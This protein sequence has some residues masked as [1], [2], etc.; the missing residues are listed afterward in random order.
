MKDFIQK[1]FKENW[2]F[3]I[4]FIMFIGIGFTYV[5]SFEKGGLVL[6]F[7]NNQS[8][9]YNVF[10]RLATLLAEGGVLAL[11]F[12]ISIWYSFGK[13][14]ILI[15]A[16]LANSIIVQFLKKIVFNMP[17]PALFYKEIVEL[18]YLEGVSINYYHS[19]PS[20]HTAT[21]FLIFSML[22]IYTR[23]KFLQFS[24]CLIAI[25]VGISRVYLLQHFVVDVVFGAMLGVA[26][27]YITFY[28][29]YDMSFLNFQKW[30]YS[31]LSQYLT[32]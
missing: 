19:F 4:P 22:A 24:L 15:V 8:E 14:V 21:A 13:A 6:Y 16:F 32:K 10:F 30:K 3:G 20:G 29:M 11:I 26:V 17:R 9:F 7:N 31:S 12:M 27:S 1:Y 23:N 5:F 18:N 2:G 25:S 28:F